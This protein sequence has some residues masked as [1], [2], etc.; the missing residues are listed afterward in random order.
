V[1]WARSPRATVAAQALH[2]TGCAL[3]TSA[4]CACPA[5][6]PRPRPPRESVRVQPWRCGVPLA[7][8]TAWS[9]SGSAAPQSVQGTGRRTHCTR[10]ASS[11]ARRTVAVHPG[12][13]QGAGAAAHARS[14]CMASSW[15]STTTSQPRWRCGQYT[16]SS[17]T[18][19]VT[20]RA[21]G[22]TSSQWH[23]RRSMGQPWQREAC[24]R[25]GTDAPARR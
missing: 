25:H 22:A 21:A 2:S 12:N 11:S 10:C 17:S 6:A 24:E 7:E 3:H 13:P 5:L 23:G 8:P 18:R 16:R 15:R 19:H 9:A 1:C 20:T 4:V 14:R